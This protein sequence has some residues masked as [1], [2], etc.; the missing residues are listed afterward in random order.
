M[1]CNEPLYYHYLDN[2]FDPNNI[3]QAICFTYPTTMLEGSFA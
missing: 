3:T 2:Q 1:N